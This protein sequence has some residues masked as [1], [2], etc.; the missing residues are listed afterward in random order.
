MSIIIPLPHIENLEIKLNKTKN[1]YKVFNIDNSKESEELYSK[2]LEAKN[3]K[4]FGEY[5]NPY[6]DFLLLSDNYF[7]GLGRYNKTHTNIYAQELYKI[8]Y[9]F[10]ETIFISKE[11][12]KISLTYYPIYK[13]FIP[14]KASKNLFMINKFSLDMFEEY[15]FFSEYNNHYSYDEENNLIFLKIHTFDKEDIIEESTED[16]IRFMKKKP[17]VKFNI[18]D[19]NICNLDYFENFVKN[20]DYRKL[21]NLMIDS[22]IYLWENKKNRAYYASQGFFNIVIISLEN[23][24]KNGNII[25]KLGSINSQLSLDLIALLQIYFE[26]VFIIKSSTS[27]VISDDKILVGKKFLGIKDI[28]YFLNLK[29]V[30]RNWY[31]YEKSCG[32]DIKTEPIEG[33]YYITSIFN[34]KGNYQNYKDFIDQENNIKFKNFEKII[35][36]YNYVKNEF[37]FSEVNGQK[38]E[39][40]LIDK[41]S[42]RSIQFLKE[43]KI[44]IKLNYSNINKEILNV[45]LD[46]N[47]RDIYKNFKNKYKL[48]TS[49]NDFEKLYKMENNLKIYKRKMDNMNMKKYYDISKI[50]IK[51]FKGLNKEVEL[52]TFCKKISQGF[53]KMYEMLTIFNL[54]DKEDFKSFHLCEAPGQFIRACKVYINRNLKNTS[55]YWNAQ[56]LHPSTGGALEDDYGLI[57]DNPNRWDFG[58]DKS[59]DITKVRNIKYYSKKFKDYDL[60][61]FDCGFNFDKDTYTQTYQDKVTVQ[62]NFASILMTLSGLKRGGNFVNKIFL[63]QTLPSIIC[64][65]YL[66]I[67]SFKDVYIYKPLQNPNSSEVYMVA[68]NF[69]GIDQEMIDKLFEIYKKKQ[70]KEFFIDLPQDFIEDYTNIITFFIQ[71]NINSLIATYYYYD[72][73]KYFKEEKN[74][75]KKKQ[76]EN[77]V[78]WLKKF[79]LYKF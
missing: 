77:V 51:P 7:F 42:Q 23:L 61:T 57:A 60:V 34:Y 47:D 37:Y 5:K 21:D 8:I 35:E 33:K 29:N 25:L 64:V 71:K 76:K 49:D 24:K 43:N 67:T 31:N 52:R 48:A 28:E 18:Y 27:R 30:L 6:W 50:F 13:K 9:K 20:N 79:N 75:I 40:Y 53:I 72:N 16:I 70:F 56:S 73:D 15:L 32:L 62:L 54:I 12:G 45:Y 4:P 22:D 36:N 46:L 63:P 55:W 1:S 17:E 14:S 41:L 26:E 2:Y 74:Y 19:E 59:G 10:T 65:N 69:K 44:P 39:K 3:L 58:A 66:V 68:K 38:A 11:M 78:N